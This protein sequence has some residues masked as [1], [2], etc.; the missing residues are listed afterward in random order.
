MSLIDVEMLERGQGSH[1][2]VDSAHMINLQYDSLVNSVRVMGKDPETVFTAREWLML[3]ISLIVDEDD[4]T[5]F[6]AEFK[7]A[8]DRALLVQSDVENVVSLE[9]WRGSSPQGG[10]RA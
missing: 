7:A 10:R 5:R 4:Q 8:W 3:A 2:L 6:T 9:A 1:W